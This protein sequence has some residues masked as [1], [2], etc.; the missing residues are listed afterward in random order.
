MKPDNYFCFSG[1]YRI[2]AAGAGYE[3]PGGLGAI[4]SSVFFLEEGSVLK[5]GIGQR[6]KQL[7]AGMSVGGG[8]GSF[9]VYETKETSGLKRPDKTEV[10]VVAGS[11]NYWFLKN[12]S[13]SFLV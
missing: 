1:L 4:M 6:G 11:W 3:G 2:V 12:D 9:V 13:L 5:I 8:G 10:L 7:G